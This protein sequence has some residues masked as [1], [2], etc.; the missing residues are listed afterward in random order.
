MC[1]QSLEAGV[2][3]FFPLLALQQLFMKLSLQTYVS[4]SHMLIFREGRRH[5]TINEVF[6][7]YQKDCGL[8]SS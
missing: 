2:G 7:L 3:I 1:L 5:E 8:L 6:I 4:F